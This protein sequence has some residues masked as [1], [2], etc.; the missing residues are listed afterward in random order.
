MLMTIDGSLG[1]GGGQILRSSLALSIITGTPF[2]IVNIRARRK[3]PGLMRQHLAAVH[4]AQAVSQAGVSGDQVGSTELVFRPA[5]VR[6]GEHRFVVGTAGSATLVFQTVLPALLRAPMPSA[7]TFEGGTHNPMAPPFE[8]VSRTFVPV[9]R[10][11]GARV[12]V[13]LERPGFYP[14]GGGRFHVQI[15]PVAA[16]QPIEL[17]DRG[18]VRR[19]E[20]EALLSDLP[21]HIAERELDALCEPLQ[22]S[23]QWGHVQQVEQ[24]LGPGNVLLATIESEH[25]T[26]VLAGFGEKG[27][28]AEEVA[29]RLAR[30]VRRYLR[31]EV[32]VGEHLADQLLLPMALAGGGVFRTLPLSRHAH[33]QIEVMRRFMECDV[34]VRDESERVVRVEVR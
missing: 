27:V 14:A 6:A 4:A 17:V 10:K 18:P 15:D 28:R 24:P 30:E 11:M 21:E 34:R 19:C 2:R 25:I 8:F 7:L 20:A 26:E 32:P 5:G 33:T 3:R 31:A 12:T 23:R 29:S 22:W 1:E 9:L 13:E 16:L